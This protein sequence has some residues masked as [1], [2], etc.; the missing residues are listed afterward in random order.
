MRPSRPGVSKARENPII[1][2]GSR[3][4]AD[5]ATLVVDD[6]LYIYAGRD[7]A[8]PQFGSFNMKEYD[9]LAT[10]DVAGGDWDHYQGAL[11][12]GDVFDWATGNAAYAGGVTEGP[13]GKYYWYAAVETKSTQYA[14]IG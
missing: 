1:S 10:T 5:A 11:S 3:Y 12:P 2:D 4:P 14:K 9:I 13:D 7:E 6:T 8:G